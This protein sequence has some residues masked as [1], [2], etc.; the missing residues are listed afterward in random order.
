MA[1]SS[2]V[3]NPNM[4]LYYDRSRLSLAARMLADGYNFR[5]KE[6]KLSN[7]NLGWNRLGTFQ[8]NGPV[9]H[10]QNFLM[11]DGTEQFIFATLTDIYRYVNDTT[12]VYLTPAY[13]TGTVSRTGNVV[14]VTGGNFTTGGVKIGDEISFGSATQNSTSA[15]WHPITVVGTTTLSTSTSGT[16]AGGTA[17]TIRKKFS[18]GVPD[19]W[20]SAIFVN[21]S[22]SNSDELW[23]TNGID[24]IVRWNG[25]STFVEQMSALGFTAKS[26]VV[27][28]NMM[29]FLNLTQGGTNKPTDMI[30]SNPGEPQNVTTGLSE[31]FKVHGHVDE[32][33]SARVLGDNLAIYSHS[34]D[35]A[36]TLTQ[37]VGDP[38]VFTFR[39]VSNGVGPFSAKAVADFG[40]YHEFLANDGEYFFDGATVKLIN[41]HVWREILRQQDPSRI[42]QAYAHFDEENGD[43]I[44]S[45]P[46]TSDL[47]PSGAPTQAV[48]EHYVENPGPNLPSPFSR[49]EFPFTT[50]GFYRR[51]TGLTWDQV[52]QEWQDVNFRWND[53]FFFSAFPFNIG[54]T[55][56]G[57]IY[58][59]NTAQDGDGTALSSYVRFGRRA[60]FDGRARG[61][62]TRVYPFVNTFVTPVNVKV[63]MSDSGDGEPMLQ[64]EQVFEQTQLEG[65][66]FTVHYRRGRFYEVEFN[67]PGPGTPWEV[68]GYDV[69]VRPGGKR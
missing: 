61:L 18:G 50:T 51:Q 32:I 6:G 17:Y 39:Q 16:V 65:A 14:T 20:Q 57:K 4:G 66:H 43:L 23:L 45:I 49:R 33:L 58:T 68:S 46:L 15:T 59:L 11:R 63:Y 9:M 1:K 19:T 37:F 8:L 64:S 42:T 38:L 53:R 62:L 60:L 10:I 12:V 55:V 3:L 13:T 69:D 44:W 5:V 47:D 25:S 29:I 28:S 41:T 54:G 67:S 30:N 40:N 2:A 26:L 56:D 21:A 22:P 36:V 27:Y 52:T 35:G 48:V 31:Q 24:A 34:N 7:L